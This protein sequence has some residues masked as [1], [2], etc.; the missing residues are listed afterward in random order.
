ML[1]KVL[2]FISSIVQAEGV[3]QREEKTICI[4]SDCK[5]V[6]ELD[7]DK[8]GVGTGSIKPGMNI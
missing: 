4:N 6:K 2:T 5:Y 3:L 1:A 7:T 8:V